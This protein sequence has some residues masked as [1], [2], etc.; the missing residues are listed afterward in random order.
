V[1][2]VASNGLPTVAPAAL[3]TVAPTLVGVVVSSLMVWFASGCTQIEEVFESRAE[4]LTAHESYTAS[5]ARAGLGESALG[6]AW[7]AAAESALAGALKVEPPYHEVGHFAAERPSAVA[8]R[9]ALRRG[10]AL[11]VTL[12]TET[13]HPVQLFVDLFR[14]VATHGAHAVEETYGEQARAATDS[15]M[16]APAGDPAQPAEQY[17]HVASAEISPRRFEFEPSRDG[18]FIIRIQ[19]ELLRSARFSVTLRASASLAFPVSGHDTG[20]IRSVFG[21]S[22]DAGR[23]RHHGVDIFAPR[24][25]PVLAAADGEVSRV[26]NRGLGGK[27]IW[28]R[29]RMRGLS[30]YYAHLDEQ[31]VRQGQ[32]VRSGDTLG[33][34]GNTGNARTT[35]PHLHFGVYRRGEGPIDP[36][37]FLHQPPQEPARVTVDTSSLGR[38]VRTTGEQ[39]LQR[40]RART[41]DEGIPL[42]RHTVLR[43]KGGTG[44]WYRVELPDG[45]PG[46]VRGRLVEDVARPVA[47]DLVTA[48]QRVLETPASRAVAVDSLQAGERVPVLG[49]FEE[50]LY[51]RTGSGRS[52][53]VAAAGR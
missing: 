45:T 3:R 27:Y 38:L 33:L 32:R 35:P 31:L 6:Q 24:G 12:E 10:Q 2:T 36:Y 11:L 25:T 16:R 30:F 21:A 34:V 5:L 52:G 14:P 28:M 43:V 39:A 9:I 47:E 23:R 4:N 22:R 13:E 49:Q 42:S 48:S 46:Y 50:F 40:S 17:R 7:L 37:H 44:G 15:S 51:I 20:A 1:K 26:R 19:P 53:W 41:A 18:D 8:Y 29:D